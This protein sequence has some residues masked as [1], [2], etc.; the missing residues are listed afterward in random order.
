MNPLRAWDAFWFGPVSARP[1]GAFRIAFGV[2]CL[3]NLAL[4]AADPDEWLTDIGYLQGQESRELAGG[5]RP[6]PLQWVQDPGSVRVFLVVTMAVAVAFTLGWRTRVMGV[7]LYLG[8]LSI[9]HRN[10]LSCSGA[11]VLLVCASFYLMLSPCGASY[12]L[13]ARRATRRRGTLAEQL[14][15]PWAQRLIQLQVSLLYLMTAFLKSTGTTW[16]D[17]T[18]LHYVLSNTEFRRWTFGLTDYPLAINVLTLGALFAEVAL[19]FLLWFRATR[20]YAMA[21]G[22]ALHGGIA[23][24]VNIPIFGE[25]LV[26]SYL[27][28]LT[29]PELDALLGRLTL[30]HWR[31]RRRDRRTPDEPAMPSRALRGPHFRRGQRAPLS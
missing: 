13:D 31:G 1:L 22:A 27:T 25:L 26:A 20:P 4:L 7:L 29:A 12:S 3:L 14:I 9:H 2:I 21:A 5:L 23:L 16:P 30:R 6:S 10:L 18:A 8:N 24:T 11:D 17:G 15:V 28:F 19:A